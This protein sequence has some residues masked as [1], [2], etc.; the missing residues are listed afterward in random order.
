MEEAQRLFPPLAPVYGAILKRRAARVDGRLLNLAL[1]TAA[2]GHGLTVREAN[3]E[4]LVIRDHVAG[5][6]WS[7]AFAAQLGVDIPVTAQRGQI[8]HLGLDVDTR[9]PDRSSARSTATT[10]C[11]GRM[12]AWWP[13]RPARLASGSGP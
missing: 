3:V 13:G 9:R 7:E 2:E 12:A 6:A 11:R 1:R 4:R 10:W 5:G 8:I